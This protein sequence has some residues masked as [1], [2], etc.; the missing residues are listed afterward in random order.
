MTNNQSYEIASGD[1]LAGNFK[2]QVMQSLNNSDDLSSGANRDRKSV[3]KEFGIVEDGLLAISEE[4]DPDEQEF[5]LCEIDLAL[6][7][8]EAICASMEEDDRDHFMSSIVKERYPN[9]TL[10]EFD[11]FKTDI[12]YKCLANTLRD[13]IGFSD[14]IGKSSEDLKG[15]GYAAQRA[16]SGE[17]ALDCLEHLEEFVEKRGLDINEGLRRAEINPE[18]YHECAHKARFEGGMERT[19]Q[20]IK[21]SNDSQAHYY[22]A[23]LG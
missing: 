21:G 3:L 7:R 14:D 9:S 13:F 8:I 1:V 22:I 17:A 20:E 23:K 4:E 11:A 19:A 6:M 15:T 16:T 18:L 12:G 2:E 10:E 5:A